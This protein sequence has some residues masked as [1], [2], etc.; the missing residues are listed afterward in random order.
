VDPKELLCSADSCI[1]ES[2]GQLLYA[3]PD[4]LSRAGAQFIASALDGC[5]R[6]TMR[7]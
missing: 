5:F 4:H 2:G 1:F 6:M 7:K 3:D